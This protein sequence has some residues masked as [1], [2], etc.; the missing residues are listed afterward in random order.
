VVDVPQVGRVVTNS[1]VSGGWDVQ[2]DHASYF[3]S[4]DKAGHEVSFNQDAPA[5]Y[6][7][8]TRYSTPAGLTQIMR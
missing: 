4:I 1:V 3:S 2:N 7:D 5:E 8:F 6:R